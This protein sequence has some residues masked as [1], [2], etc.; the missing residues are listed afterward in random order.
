MFL[1]LWFLSLYNTL[2]VYRKKNTCSEKE[3][4]AGMQVLCT[5]NNHTST[6]M[7]GSLGS[8]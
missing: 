5:C 4:V 6:V 3:Q 2:F 7:E 1:F 8:Y